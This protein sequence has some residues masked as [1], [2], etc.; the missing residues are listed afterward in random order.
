M[1][2]Q[3]LSSVDKVQETV[4]NGQLKAVMNVVDSSY[5]AL[6]ANEPHNKI[7][8]P[9]FVA[10]FLPYFTGKKVEDPA[11][12]PMA[13][14]IGVAGSATSKVDVID[15]AGEVLFT[16]P[17]MMDSTII[18]LNQTGGKRLND[19]VTDYQLHRESLPGAAANFYNREFNNKLKQI[20]PGHVDETQASKQWRSIFDRYNVVPLV[21][22]KGTDAK[23]AGQEDDLVY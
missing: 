16:V 7:P 21:D 8:E 3:E 9:I 13:E 4:V 12:N 15:D 17:P 18:N 2:G 10:H 14:W 22:D 1:S 23:A 20:V 5:D 11:R 19:L 6:V